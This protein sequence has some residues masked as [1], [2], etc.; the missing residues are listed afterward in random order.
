MRAYHLTGVADSPLELLELDT[1]QPGPGEVAVRV[2]AT[3]LNYR[4]L[5]ISRR[6]RRGIVPLSDGAG[7]VLTLDEI[8]SIHLYT[9]QSALYPILNRRLRSP[10]IFM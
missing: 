4:D 2:R 5:M 9:Q 8:A 10:S 1:P 3:S 7:E 6:G